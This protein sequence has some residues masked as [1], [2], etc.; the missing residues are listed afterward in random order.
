MFFIDSVWVSFFFCHEWNCPA[1]MLCGMQDSQHWCI[2]YNFWFI[3]I[4]WFG[5]GPYN[6]FIEGL[7]LVKINK[8]L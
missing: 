8:K 5:Y 1:K 4:I 6:V 3:N 2:Q 7:W